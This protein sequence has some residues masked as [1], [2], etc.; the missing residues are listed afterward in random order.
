VSADPSLPYA[1]ASVAEALLVMERDL[2]QG[3]RLA[4][5]LDDAVARKEMLHAMRRAAD[6]GITQQL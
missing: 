3:T 1:A 4:L 5:T 2:R 6:T